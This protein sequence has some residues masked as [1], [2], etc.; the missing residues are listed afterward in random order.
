MN[1]IVKKICLLGDPAV[2]KTSLV[3]RFVENMFDDRYLRTIG[4]KTS[5]KVIEVDNK[6]L[7]LMIWDVLGQKF[8]GYHSAYYRG[9]KGAIVVGDIS[10]EDTIKSMESW[11]RAFKQ[12][13]PESEITTVVNKIDL[14]KNT[15]EKEISRIIGNEAIYTSAKTGD[16]VEEAFLSI[17]EKMLRAQEVLE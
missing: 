16:G 1:K 9:A 12:E 4:T 15:D 6:S 7:T 13:N 11:I 2:G 14:K 17:S 5:K 8:S 3:T 10:R